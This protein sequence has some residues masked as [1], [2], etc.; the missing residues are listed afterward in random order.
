M[1]DSIQLVVALM[2]FKIWLAF[3]FTMVPIK[4][5]DYFVLEKR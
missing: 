2:V 1:T 4:L 3:I 5:F